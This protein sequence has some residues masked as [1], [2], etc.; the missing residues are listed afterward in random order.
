LAGEETMVRRPEFYRFRPGLLLVALVLISGTAGIRTASAEISYQQ[1]L[2]APDDL[3]LNLQ[4]ARQ[5]VKSGR[6]QQAAAALERLLLQRPNWDSL[7]LF[8]GIVL[9]RL[10]DMD[11]ARRELTL[12]EGRSLNPAQ[13]ADRAKYLDLATKKSKPVRVTGRLSFGGRYDSNPGRV[14]DILTS[15][16][17]MD[18]GSDFAL[19][20]DSRLRVESDLNNGRGDYA[21]V[22]FD[23]DLRDYFTINR[24]DG[25]RLWGR[26]GFKFHGANASFTPYATYGTSWLQYE[27]FRSLYGGGFDSTMT[28]SSQVALL[29]KARVARE[30]YKTTSYSTIGSDRDGWNV[31]GG[32]YIRWRQSDS[33]FVTAGGNWTEKDALNDGFSYGSGQ[34]LVA[35]HKLLG[36]GRYVSLSAS[37][38]HTDYQQP[39]GFYSNTITR[40]DDIFRIKA[41]TGAPLANIFSDVDF[42]RE[43]GE[44]VAQ[45]GATYYTQ[46]SSINELEVD[47]IG[48]EILFT[49]R[50]SF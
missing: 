31:R 1:I 41:A 18:S 50:F 14:S 2:D 16:T 15:T 17:V 9:Y 19:A 39:D 10:D 5:E 30:E 35:A 45:F 27:N 3:R 26:A 28:L 11:G 36:K 4:Y 8:Y 20:A 37:G 25:A 24:A 46:N 29:L 47:N 21:F 44:V 33:L 48:L 23:G 49:K 34:L 40:K 7:R 42:S 38:R 22:Q 12:L 6:L 32:A 13:D 43:L